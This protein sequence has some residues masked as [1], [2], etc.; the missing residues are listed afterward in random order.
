MSAPSVRQTG[1]ASRKFE[2]D[3][4]RSEANRALATSQSHWFSTSAHQHAGA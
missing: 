4:L 2:A 1:N 3:G